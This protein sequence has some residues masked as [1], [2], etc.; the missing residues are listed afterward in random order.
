MFRRYCSI[1]RKQS[2]RLPVSELHKSA[3]KQ[4]KQHVEAAGASNKRLV[5]SLL[6]C[7]EVH[8][9]TRACPCFYFTPVESAP[10]YSLAIWN[11][12]ISEAETDGY[13]I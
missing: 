6:F 13:N 12:P 4:G 10:A 9:S 2:H 1:E 5:I 7:P 11:L 8:V 3:N